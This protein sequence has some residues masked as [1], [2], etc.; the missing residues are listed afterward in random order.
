MSMGIL[1]LIN[2]PIPRMTSMPFESTIIRLATQSTPPPHP[3][4][5]VQLKAYCLPDTSLL[6]LLTSIQNNIGSLEYLRGYMVNLFS[7]VIL[8]VLAMVGFPR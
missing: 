3:H 6:R 7:N 4:F 5:K 2:Q 1:C 8:L